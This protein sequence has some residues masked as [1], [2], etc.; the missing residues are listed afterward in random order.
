M[1]YDPDI[2]MIDG[3]QYVVATLDW[4]ED[5][6]ERQYEIE[7][8]LDGGIFPFPSELMQYVGRSDKNK[9]LIYEGDIVLAADGKRY[10]VEYHDYFFA[11]YKVNP[12]G[13]QSWTGFDYNSPLEVVGN[14]YQH[15]D[16]L[17]K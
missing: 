8:Y 12:D 14:I 6:K 11:L 13:S 9:N 10:A 7:G 4:N 3:G 17:D 1:I 2:L 5:I 16:L 15:L